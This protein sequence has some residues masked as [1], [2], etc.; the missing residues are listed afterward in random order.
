MK[1]IA[2]LI[3]IYLGLN[4]LCGFAQIPSE[5]N[6]QAVIRDDSENLIVNKD[7]SLKISILDETET[8]LV[9]YSETHVITSNFYGMININIGGGTPVLNSFSDIAWGSGA[10]FLKVELDITGGS[11]YSEVGISALSSVPFANHANTASGLGTDKVYST[12]SDTLFVVKD[13]DGNVV[14]VVFPDGVQVIANESAKGKVGGFAVSG[15][16]PNGLEPLTALRE[17]RV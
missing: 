17:A 10:K 6:Y 12:E 9:L 13:H 7:V 16:N 1:R 11:D 15:R 5:F 4:T 8:G 3:L 2:F 14:F